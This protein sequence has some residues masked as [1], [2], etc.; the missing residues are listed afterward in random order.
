MFPQVTFVSHDDARHQGPHGVFAALF[1]PLRDA[2][3]GWQIG[4]VIHKDDGVNAAVVVLHH[5]LPETLLTRGVP[6]L[7]L[8]K[9][10]EA[11]SLLFSAH[12]ARVTLSFSYRAINR[13]EKTNDNMENVI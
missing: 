2:F 1:D 5:A 13:D 11:D 9:G 8:E 3:E 12:T 4:H 6:N 7:Q 10:A